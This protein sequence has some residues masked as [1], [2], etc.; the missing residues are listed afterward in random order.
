MVL[1][2]PDRRRRLREML[3]PLA[4]PPGDAQVHFGAVDAIIAGVEL[5]ARAIQAREIQIRTMAPFGY[6]RHGF[7][8]CQGS[9]GF[10]HDFAQR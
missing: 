10:I 9:V 4:H 3:V 6:D 8:D 7:E 1:S 2:R 5:R